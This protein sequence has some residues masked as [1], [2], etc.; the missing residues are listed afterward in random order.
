MKPSVSWERILSEDEL[1]TLG[2]LCDEIIPADE[3]SPAASQVGVPDFINEW[4][5]APYS[6]QQED[7]VQIR[8]G[9]VWLDTEAQRR[10]SKKF[11]ALPS[12]AKQSICDDICHLP[13]AKPEHLAAARFFAKLRDLTTTGFYTTTAGSKDLKY[14]GNVP[15]LKFSGPP[16]EVLAHLKLS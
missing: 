8:G 16:P 3:Y 14:I 7:R 12:E 11:A 15:L 10:F 13:K 1:R 6:V 9:L 5:S 2:A 4:V